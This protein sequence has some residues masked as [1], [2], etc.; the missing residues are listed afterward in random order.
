MVQAKLSSTTFPSVADLQLDVD[1]KFARSSVG[2]QLKFKDNQVAIL[3]NMDSDWGSHRKHAR[4]SYDGS[5]K[6]SLEAALEGMSQLVANVIYNE[7]KL[8]ELSISYRPE[9]GDFSFGKH[10]VYVTFTDKTGIPQNFNFVVGLDSKKIFVNVQTPFTNWTNV[11]VDGQISS[12]SVAKGIKFLLQR[13]GESIQ[14]SFE[15]KNSRKTGTLQIF[16]ELSVVGFSQLRKLLLERAQATDINGLSAVTPQKFTFQLAWSSAN[17]NV[18]VDTPVDVLKSL[19]CSG[20]WEFKK[21]QKFITITGQINERQYDFQTNIHHQ[22]E[23]CKGKL[24]LTS[25]EYSLQL[26]YDFTTDYEVN[27]AMETPNRQWN[28]GAKVIIKPN[29]IG[30][31]LQTPVRNYEAITLSAQQEFPAGNQGLYTLSWN[32]NGKSDSIELKY[33][34]EQGRTELRAS[35][36][37]A[38]WNSVVITVIYNTPF[39]HFTFHSQRGDGQEVKINFEMDASGNIT[40]FDEPASSSIHIAIETPVENFRDIKF[41]LVY[42]RQN[43][44]HAANFSVT[45]NAGET[46]GKLN[47]RFQHSDPVALDISA[48]LTSPFLASKATAHASLLVDPNGESTISA[49]VQANGKRYEMYALS[50]LTSAITKLEMRTSLPFLRQVKFSVNKASTITMHGAWTGNNRHVEI[51]GDVLCTGLRSSRVSFNVS[52]PTDLMGSFGFEGEVSSKSGVTNGKLV[53]QNHEVRWLAKVDRVQEAGKEDWR[54]QVNTPLVGY[55]HVVISL[56]HGI[57]SLERNVVAVVQLNKKEMSMRLNFHK[58]QKLDMVLTSELS[59]L[60]VQAKVS[61]DWENKLSLAISTTTG[62]AEYGTAFRLHLQGMSEGNVEF[63]ISSMDHLNTKVDWKLQGDGSRGHG[64]LN[65]KNTLVGS[66]SLRYSWENENWQDAYLDVWMRTGSEENEKGITLR[67]KVTPHTHYGAIK[68]IANYTLSESDDMKT[69]LFEASLDEQASQINFDSSLKTPFED[70]EIFEV[71]GHLKMKNEI[72]FSINANTNEEKLVSGNLNLVVRPFNSE[73]QMK[74]D[75][76]SLI[77][78]LEL[79]TSYD[80]TSANKLVVVE[81]K[82]D[83][84]TMNLRLA[85]SVPSSEENSLVDVTLQADSTVPNIPLDVSGTLRMEYAFNKDDGTRQISIHL[86]GNEVGEWKLLA[87]LRPTANLHGK[88]VFEGPL[89]VLPTLLAEFNFGGNLGQNI[90]SDL[91]VIVASTELTGSVLVTNEQWVSSFALRYTEGGSYSGTAQ[92]NFEGSHTQLDIRFSDGD[93]FTLH[94]SGHANVT[95]ETKRGTG[96]V[97]VTSGTNSAVPVSFEIVME[98]SGNIL[99]IGSSHENNLKVEANLIGS[100]GQAWATEGETNFKVEGNILG[101]ENIEF[102]W[103]STHFVRDDEFSLNASTSQEFYVESY[104]RTREDPTFL[105]KLKS[106]SGTTMEE[107]KLDIKLLPSNIDVSTIK[108]TFLT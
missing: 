66:K 31:V 107:I 41:S 39:K 20:N 84:Y 56:K 70:F 18:K 49:H 38:P 5:I 79:T 78:A 21:P 26:D 24:S 25:D 12:T 100:N 106:S 55:K 104:V 27:V 17:F 54:L 102:Q 88:I 28:V 47:L 37:F 58:D 91:T 99:I 6:F 14:G 48:Y 62:N 95:T 51:H 13:E 44:V 4:V 63:A 89:T 101:E 35:T 23:N 96:I 61:A 76:P 98:N 19:S 74:L 68:A 82:Q 10:G 16:A 87:S 94:I 105:V 71:K 33:E 7:E 15:S 46:E 92:V 11:V 9:Q 65:I 81:F 53:F 59:Y 86:N 30:L 90:S 2:G 69:I 93:D 42:D 50:Q 3:A 85:V 72:G 103:Q 8:A 34:I 43:L 77:E 57:N 80:L 45:R 36:P 97:T 40:A 60:P 73:L 67:Y 64:L 75:I 52:T 1:Y 22:N 108:K 29:M 83:A 32:V